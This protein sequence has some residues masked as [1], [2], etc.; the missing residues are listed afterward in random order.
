MF[1]KLRLK[2]APTNSRRSAAQV[3]AFQGLANLLPMPATVNIIASASPMS[4]GSRKAII[5]SL[6][7]GLVSHLVPLCPLP[8]K[9]WLCWSPASD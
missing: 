7:A 1:G 5:T 2:F 9:S 3:F 8:R 6:Q 4:V